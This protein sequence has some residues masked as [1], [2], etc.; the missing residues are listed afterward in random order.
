MH[1]MH[2][3]AMHLA[4]MHVT[5]AAAMHVMHAAAMH[6]AYC[7]L[8]DRC[9]GILLMPFWFSSKVETTQVSYLYIAWWSHTV[10]A[11]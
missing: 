5:H 8:V 6:Q 1:V 7:Q 2:V 11:T 9:I 4:A 10:T 3:A